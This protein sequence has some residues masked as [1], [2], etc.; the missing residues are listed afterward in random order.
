MALVSGLVH[1]LMQKAPSLE[2]RL[3][4]ASQSGDVDPDLTK[5]ISLKCPQ[6]QV[7]PSRQVWQQLWFCWFPIPLSSELSS[8]VT[9]E[10]C[11]GTQS[12]DSL[13]SA[14]DDRSWQPRRGAAESVPWPQDAWRGAHG[15]L[16]AIPEL[17]FVWHGSSSPQERFLGLLMEKEERAG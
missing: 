16:P 2:P 4:L 8:G 11:R 10:R 1:L 17:W 14:E 12:W 9:A 6:R 3:V 13:P 7:T 15:G 5:L